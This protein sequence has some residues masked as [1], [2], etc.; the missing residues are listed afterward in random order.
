MTEIAEPE[1]AA[2]ASVPA[3][4]SV[5]A[6]APTAGPAP[7]PG[8]AARA[9]ARAKRDGGIAQ[10]L[11]GLFAVWAFAL[12]SRTGSGAEAVLGFKL[13]PGQAGG[14]SP[15]SLPAGPAALALAL[16]AAACGV[17][18]IFAPLSGR[19]LNWLA[20]LYFVSFIGSFLVWTHAGT[21]TAINLP[22][23]VEESAI[24]AV[25]LVLGSLSALLC[26]KSGV[27]NIAI[28][29]QFLFG[30][31]AGALTSSMTGSAWAGVAAGCLGGV[32]MS[33]LLAVFANRY[34]IE[35][36]VLG[37]V[38]NL[39][40]SGLTGFFYDRL[41]SQN[42]VEYDSPAILG[43]LR[44]P[45]LASLPVL[46]ALFDQNLVFYA[47]YLLVP[48]VWYLLM[49]TRWGLRTRAVGEHP[50]AADTVGVKVLALRYRNVLVAGVLS[51][52]GGVWLT[53]GSVGPFDKDMSAGLGYVAIAALIVGRWNAFGAL[54]ASLLFGFTVELD[55]ALSGLNTPIPGAALQM[56]PYLVTILVVATLGGAV[57]PPAA[58]NKPYVK[59]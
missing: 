53:V 23:V 56:A 52:L 36:V 1:D 43:Q 37:V 4:D 31:F 24:G 9:A 10:A 8:K 33:A 41:M 27:V 17:V 38:L 18:R 3:P 34:L 50:T 42:S 45:G 29:G 13:D 20:G 28:E 46:G 32:L 6:A 58:S 5:P 2:A 15:L 35:Q 25:P 19:T 59:Q 39:L 7:T 21:G 40:A 16:L 55:N 44:I 47:A 48:A 14:I 51:G 22:G 30:A 57:R 12:G 26:E 11:V 49:R 54:A